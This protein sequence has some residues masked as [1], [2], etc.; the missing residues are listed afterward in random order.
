MANQAKQ[1]TLSAE[2]LAQE[3]VFSDLISREFKPKTEQAREAV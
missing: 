3:S 1:E 2:S